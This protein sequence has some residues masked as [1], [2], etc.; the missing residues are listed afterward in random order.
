MKKP[1][2]KKLF[3]LWSVCEL[4]YYFPSSSNSVYFFLLFCV[5]GCLMTFNRCK[6]F[7]KLSWFAF[8]TASQLDLN[9]TWKYIK[10]SLFV[11]WS[12][13]RSSVMLFVMMRQPSMGIKLWGNYT[14]QGT[15]NQESNTRGTCQKWGETS[16]FLYMPEP[17]T[18]LYYSCSHEH[19]L[20]M[21]HWCY[22]G[23]I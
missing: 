12:S 3:R 7:Q 11:F 6:C 13:D 15:S 1:V 8:V 10:K 14:S 5:R 20:G 2:W 23:E 19:S 9:C 16:T 17:H 22:L 4:W 21:R 18:L